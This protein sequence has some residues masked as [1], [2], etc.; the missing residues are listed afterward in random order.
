MQ[1]RLR[2]LV[3]LLLAVAAALLP[4]VPVDLLYCRCTGDLSVGAMP[5]DCCAP[6]APAAPPC[7]APAPLPGP[8]AKSADLRTPSSWGCMEA[9][10]V[11]GPGA[12]ATAPAA[13]HASLPAAAASPSL[14]PVPAAA[15]LLPAAAAAPPGA[16]PPPAA[17]PRL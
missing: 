14:L 3:L 9:W 4:A 16:L 5:S 6:A 11:G 12:A 17:H 8:S 10:Q 15:D 13:A 2:P 1:P 7:C